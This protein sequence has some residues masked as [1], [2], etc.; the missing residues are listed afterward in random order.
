MNSKSTTP[1]VHP[2]EL[3]HTYRLLSTLPLGKKSCDEIEQ[4]AD[5]LAGARSLLELNQLI[6]PLRQGSD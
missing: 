6:R 4:L 2:L 3:R 1:W 5:R